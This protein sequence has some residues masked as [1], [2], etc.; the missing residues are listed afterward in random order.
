MSVSTTAEPPSPAHD[1]SEA[2][3]K[4]VRPPPLFP[5]RA[6]HF[7]PKAATELQVAAP[8]PFSRALSGD[9]PETTRE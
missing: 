2:K 7:T 4:H 6:A 1:G 3:C 8:Y 5:A 9:C